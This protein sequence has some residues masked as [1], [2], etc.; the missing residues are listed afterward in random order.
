MCW[1]VVETDVGNTRVFSRL[2]LDRAAAVVVLL[3]IDRVRAFEYESD[4][5][6]TF[7][8]TGKKCEGV[9]VEACELVGRNGRRAA[10]RVPVAG[11]KEGLR[12]LN[13][14]SVRLYF[15]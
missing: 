15:I 2:P 11:A 7:N 9:E 13:A 14:R 1:A 12:E 10:H 8:L 4:P 6:I 3:K 5:S